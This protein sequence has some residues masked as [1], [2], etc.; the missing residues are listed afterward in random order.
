MPNRSKQNAHVILTAMKRVRLLATAAACAWLALAAPAAYGQQSSANYKTEEFFFGAGGDVDLNSA[1]YKGQL[2][3]GALGVG[4]GSS[5]NYD[6]LGGFLTLSDEYL[7]MVVSNASVNFGTLDPAT[8]SYGAAQGGSCNCSFTVRSYTTSGYTVVTVSQPP[9]SEGGA[10]LD[11][12]T[13]Q[14]APS[15]STSVEEF[16]INLVANTSPGTFGA[17][18]VNQPDNSFADGGAAAGYQTTNQYKYNPGDVIARSQITAGNLAYGQTDYT[19]SYIA[20][21]KNFTE[22][23]F[24]QMSHVLVVVATF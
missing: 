23:G 11:A 5:A 14:G 3:A 15:G 22:A 18:P 20:K 16:G 17:N 13:T 19:I 7:E 21:P 6:G 12:K 1:N 2:S 8:T 24:Y 10:V 4:Q 9:T